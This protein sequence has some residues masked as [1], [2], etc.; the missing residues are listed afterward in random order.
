MEVTDIDVYNFKISNL[1]QPKKKKKNHN[2]SVGRW[3]CVYRR[4]IKM[5]QNSITA[6]LGDSYFEAYILN[7]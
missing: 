3:T 1:V 4:E 7:F 2:D 5:R 6:N